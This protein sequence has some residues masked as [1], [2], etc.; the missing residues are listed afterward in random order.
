MKDNLEL[1]IGDH[2]LVWVLMSGSGFIV[3]FVIAMAIWR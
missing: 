2:L 1:T 3:G